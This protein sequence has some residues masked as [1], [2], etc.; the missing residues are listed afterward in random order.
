MAHGEEVSEIVQRI[1]DGVLCHPRISPAFTF[2]TLEH[3]HYGFASKVIGDTSGETSEGVTKL[4]A[5]ALLDLLDRP[6]TTDDLQEPSEAK[7][8]LLVRAL[9]TMRVVLEVLLQSL[10]D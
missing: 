2:E 4:D 1:V 3:V 6:V 5:V 10:R 8:L 9:L 7:M